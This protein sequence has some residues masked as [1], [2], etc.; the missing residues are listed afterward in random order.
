MYY[1][2]ERVPR[3]NDDDKLIDEFVATRSMFP[4][5]FKTAVKQKTRWILGITMQSFRFKDIFRIKGLRFAGRYSLYKDMKAKVGNLL[6]ILG[7]PV[8]IYFLVSLFIPDIPLIYPQGTLSWYLCL[9]VTG[10]MVERQLFRS[11]AIFNVYG[12][13]SVFFGCLLPPVLPIR[14]IWGNIIN[15][16]ADRKSVV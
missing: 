5:T 11:A 6:I 10:M 7:Y 1:V 8:L 12:M 3:I 13:R 16:S 9:A 14:M 4:K 2:L 15:M